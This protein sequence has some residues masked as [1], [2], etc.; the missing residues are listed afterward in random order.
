MG[1]NKNKALNMFLQYLDRILEPNTSKCD[2]Y[3]NA[4]M[5][6]VNFTYNTSKKLPSLSRRSLIRANTL[7]GIGNKKKSDD[8]KIRLFYKQYSM[9]VNQEG[10]Q[11]FLDIWK[12]IVQ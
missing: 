9:K 4:F 7:Q 8:L 12:K 2:R 10:D 11:K 1:S 5:N 3:E 6:L